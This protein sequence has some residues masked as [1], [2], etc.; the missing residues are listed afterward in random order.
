M[1]LGLERKKSR[2][3]AGK[4]SSGHPIL[5]VAKFGQKLF[6]INSIK[7]GRAEE[8][9]FGS[10][11]RRVLGYDIYLIGCKRSVFIYKFTNETLELISF[12]SDAH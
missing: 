4:F 2:Q 10:I 6:K 9:G 3:A 1:I 12:V 8:I 5:F 11:I 7:L